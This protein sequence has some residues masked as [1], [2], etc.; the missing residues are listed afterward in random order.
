V[1]R[2]IERRLTKPLI[3]S[4]KEVKNWRIIRKE[5]NGGGQMQSIWDGE[6]RL[7][8]SEKALKGVKG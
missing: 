7:I 3:R 1:F 2:R 6:G 5:G 4:E 8:I